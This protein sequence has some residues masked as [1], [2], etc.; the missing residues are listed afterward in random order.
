MDIVTDNWL[1]AFGRLR[2][3]CDKR[4]RAIAER[5]FSQWERL[6]AA[7]PYA[8][9]DFGITFTVDG[10]S[11]SLPMVG[12]N[13]PDTGPYVMVAGS[14][15]E[16]TP[17]LPVSP[18]ATE[19]PWYLVDDAE[20]TNAVA[21]QGVRVPSYAEGYLLSTHWT[22]VTEEVHTGTCAHCDRPGRTQLH[23]LSY[24]SH[25][26]ERPGDLLELCA[27]CH[28]RQH[29]RLVWPKAA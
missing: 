20:W 21:H 6:K 23:H 19:T 24:A 12:I 5:F 1:Q 22:L 25:G 8:A 17:Q 11:P 28:R 9:I 29:P 27:Q 14:I 3:S 16:N 15:M 10:N 4:R 13:D 7:P 26:A 18:A 2:F